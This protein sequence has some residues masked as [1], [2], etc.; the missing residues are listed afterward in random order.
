M[1]PPQVVLFEVDD[2]DRLGWTRDD[3]TGRQL[4]C[5]EDV[6]KKIGCEVNKVIIQRMEGESVDWPIQINVTF[7]AEDD[8]VFVEDETIAI[9]EDGMYHL[10]F[11]SCDP[12]IT[13]LKVSGS[14]VWKNPRGY[15]PGMMG[16]NL[17]FFGMLSL[18][19]LMLGLAWML[20]MAVRWRD[21]I[22]LHYYVGFVVLL[23]M[24]EASMWCGRASRP[25]R[26]P[27]S[28]PPALLAPYP[29]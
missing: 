29:G 9:E 3:G 2:R 20:V 17:P 11:V 12:T 19:F 25:P 27:P 28:S 14:T 6:S 23:G 4:C 26:P 16:P 21:L 18:C 22:N 1:S 24:L 5:T 7:E 13:G 8:V 15:L 10:W